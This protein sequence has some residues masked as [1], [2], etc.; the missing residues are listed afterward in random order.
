DLILVALGAICRRWT[1][2]GSA[3]MTD[4]PVPAARI[5]VVLAV[6]VGALQQE[7]E[8]VRPSDCRQ[9]RMPGSALGPDRLDT[10]EEGGLDRRR[11]PSLALFL[12]GAALVADDPPSGE[13]GAQDSGKSGLREGR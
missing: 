7:P 8:R 12:V 1:A 3:R 11:E 13:R 10:F 6:A 4:T 2:G 5:S 9:T